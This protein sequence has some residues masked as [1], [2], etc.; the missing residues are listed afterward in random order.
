MRSTPTILRKPQGLPFEEERKRKTTHF[1]PSPCARTYRCAITTVPLLAFPRLSATTKRN[2]LPLLPLI[3]SA[4]L[5]ICLRGDFSLPSN[6][7]KWTDFI[8]FFFSFRH[9]FRI[10]SIKV[11][12][13]QK[14][15]AK[16]D[17]RRL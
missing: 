16:C 11:R 5:R 12:I 3:P 10:V 15:E 8:F 6:E 9:K 4:F 7:G 2:L 1:G 17:K 14:S 13:I